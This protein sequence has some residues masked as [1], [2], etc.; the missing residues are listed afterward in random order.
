MLWYKWTSVI[1]FLL[2]CRFFKKHPE[3]KTYHKKLGNLP[4]DHEELWA[5][6]DFEDV[7][8]E[9]F[10][11]IGEVMLA[12]ENVDVGIEAIKEAASKYKG[13]GVPI[14]YFEVMNIDLYQESKVAL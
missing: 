3:Y 9:T 13:D 4:E 8:M 5:N 1:L 10:E 12:I 11:V 7:S 14:K 6:T 2:A